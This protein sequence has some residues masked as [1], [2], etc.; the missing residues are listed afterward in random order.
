MRELSGISAVVAA[1]NYQKL[2]AVYKD[3]TVRLI[4]LAGD[5]PAGS[6]QI[7]GTHE[8]DSLIGLA[9]MAISPDA[10]WLVTKCQTTSPTTKVR[11]YVWDLK[12]KDIAESCQKL[13]GKKQFTYGNGLAIDN[14]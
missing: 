12:A 10:R 7:I 4:D 14:N 1:K 9:E 2:A 3:D 13:D 5:D 11:I 8:V 6:A